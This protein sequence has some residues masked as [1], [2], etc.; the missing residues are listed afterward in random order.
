MTLISALIKNLKR[1]VFAKTALFFSFLLLSACGL[2]NLKPN[3]ATYDFYL[4]NMDTGA[5]CK[6]Y[7]DPSININC[8]SLVPTNFHHFDVKVIENIYQQQITEPNRVLSLMTIMTA[9]DNLDYTA[10]QLEDGRYQLP[11]N[12]QTDT[13]WDVLIRIDNN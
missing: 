9:G 13:V 10:I 11:K 1:P 4:L 7:N 12:Q 8:R 3:F 6:G 2:S 5:F